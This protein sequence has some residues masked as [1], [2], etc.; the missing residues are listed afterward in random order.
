MLDLAP[1][2]TD[3]DQLLRA[4]RPLYDELLG[5]ERKA[6]ASRLL[7]QVG[8]AALAGGAPDLQDDPLRNELTELERD[9]EG[10]RDPDDGDPSVRTRLKEGLQRLGRARLD[11]RRSGEGPTDDP[12]VEE[13][14]A[15]FEEAAKAKKSGS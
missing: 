2:E 7:F 3:R 15:L 10:G 1:G 13:L 11:K 9:L 5:T 6:R 14:V 12:D 4:V 8:L